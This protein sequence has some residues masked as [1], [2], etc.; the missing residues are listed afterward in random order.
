MTELARD[1]AGTPVGVERNPEAGELDRVTVQPGLDEVH[2]RRADERRHEEVDGL[3]VERLRRV[4][5]L[6]GAVAHHGHARPE[7]H[8]LDLVMR[9]VDGRDP[10]PV[11]QP[12]QLGAHVDTELGVEVRERLVHQEGLRLAD[13]RPAH[14]D[15][16][17]LAA[18]ER[19]RSAL[20]QVLQPEQPRDVLDAALDLRLRRLAHL[21]AVAE[22]LRDGHVRVEGVVLEDHR[23]VA[24]A[25]RQARNLAVADPDLPLGHHLEPGDHP[26]QCRLA[27]AGRADEDH[28]LT[29]LDRQ[30]DVVDRAHVAVVD[31]PHPLE[32]DL[33]HLELLRV[34]ACT[35]SLTP[36]T[37]L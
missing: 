30:I 16:L 13:D 33:G 14:G 8:R 23:D 19:A 18:R 6:D 25:G 21:Q 2:R 10:E 15:A 12:R 31:L 1:G 37:I 27:A 5:L 22:V 28:E 7:R 9:D 11:V 29:A 20:E 4:H 36:A 17:A 32:S 35:A 24:V 3:A 26:Q 34:D